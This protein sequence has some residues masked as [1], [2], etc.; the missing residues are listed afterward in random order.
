MITIREEQPEDIE[1][2]HHMEEQAFGQ[3][4]E[5]DLVDALRRA[6]AFVLSLVALS[7]GEIVGHILFTR[8]T[9]EDDHSDHD[10]LALG[11][12]AVLPSYQN[13]GIGT[14]LMEKGLEM[15]E[16]AGHN[17]VFLLGHPNYYPRFGFV[18]GST[19]G[20]GNEYNADDAFMVKELSV[21]ALERTKGVAKYHPEF[22]KV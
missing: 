4:D 18:K 13:R 11:P 16:K 14:Q 9:I 19:K 10:A 12:L 1:A 15:C 8:G 7:D 5:A 3:P 21:G 22:M 2:I 17:V 20:I 6:D